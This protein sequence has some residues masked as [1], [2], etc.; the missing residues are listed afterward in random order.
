MKSKI[1]KI[2][3]VTMLALSMP[4]TLIFAIN[5]QKDNI[6]QTQDETASQDQEMNE[7]ESSEQEHVQIENTYQEAIEIDEDQKLQEKAYIVVDGTTESI[8]VGQTAQ[9]QIVV[10]LS[11]IQAEYYDVNIVVDLPT[12]INGDT[13]SFNQPL[14]NLAIKGVVPTYNQVSKQLSYHFPILE[15]GFESSV[16]VIIQTKNGAALNNQKLAVA[17]TIGYADSNVQTQ[18]AEITIMATQNASLSNQITGVIRDGEMTALSDHELDGSEAGVMEN[19][20]GVRYGDEAI[21]SLAA[22]VNKFQTGSIALKAGSNVVLSYVLDDGLEYISDTSEVTPS[23]NGNKYTWTFPVNLNEDDVYYFVKNFDVHTKVARDLTVF[24][25]LKNNAQLQ[26]TYTDDKTVDYQSDATVIVTPDSSYMTELELQGSAFKSLFNG[27]KD[28]TGEVIPYDNVDPQVTDG[29]LLGWGFYLSPLSATNPYKGMNAYDVF[30]HPDENLNIYQIYSGNFYY[31]PSSLFITNGRQPL[32]EPLYYSISI[33]YTDEEKWYQGLE[34]ISPGKYYRAEA[35]GIDTNRK[36]K[37]LWFHFHNN[38]EGQFANDVGYSKES[39]LPAGMNTSNFTIWTTIDEGYVGN[40]ESKGAISYS[41]WNAK[42]RK[43]GGNSKY[44]PTE[45][46]RPDLISP[47]L[48]NA[49]E[50]RLIPKTAKVIVPPEGVGRYVKGN[51]YFAKAEKNI[52]SPGA[53]H[54]TVS[55]A[56][57]AASLKK[58]NGP[59]ETYVLLDQGV[60]VGDLSQTF[61]GKA[62]VVSTNYQNT[63]KT[64]VKLQPDKKSLIIGNSTYMQFPVTVTKQAGYNI[65]LSL[66]GYLSDDF[67]VSQV[68]NSNGTFTV[69]ELESFDFNDNQETEMVYVTRNQYN[70]VHA[71]E[72]YGTLQ[73]SSNNIDFSQTTTIYND[74]K[75]TLKFD[76]HNTVKTPI[77][78]FILIGVLP[79]VNDTFVLNDSARYSKF[80]MNLTGPIKLAAPYDTIFEVF[81][82]TSKEPL[83]AGVLDANTDARLN[84]IVAPTLVDDQP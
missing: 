36:V 70:Y 20:I 28:G 40:I 63:G 82:S 17:G 13:I 59:F 61:N 78:D 75:T 83:V 47:T 44:V 53:N 22:S 2:L 81:Y 19:V 7:D 31:I 52:V 68:S 65:E 32:V 8:E 24:S 39:G 77:S 18:S 34:S 48:S 5:S 27:P 66:H 60:V 11:N 10:S 84:K 74:R 16:I 80:T 46:K 29:A 6:N 14:S 45:L 33:K 72:F 62:S 54:V 41:G 9:F 3:I 73:G 71:Y 15:G 55:I 23:V 26:V 50:E 4:T 58:L 43:V 56:N 49:F 51:V 37:T 67:A 1:I 57:D 35:L 21:F 79:T 38:Q 30:F 69:K 12:I 76:L 42:G 25:K 64:L